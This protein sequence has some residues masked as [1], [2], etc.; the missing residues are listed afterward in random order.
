MF[1]GKTENRHVAKISSFVS[2]SFSK[3]CKT[4]QTESDLIKPLTPGKTGEARKNEQKTNEFA[5]IQPNPA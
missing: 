2:Q 3:P 1:R 5:K 4:N